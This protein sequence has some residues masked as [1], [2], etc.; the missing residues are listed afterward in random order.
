[1]FLSSKYWIEAEAVGKELLEFPQAESDLKLQFRLG[2]VYMGKKDFEIAANHFIAAVNADPTNT[3]CQK[4]MEYA[5]KKSRQRQARTKA[6]FGRIFES[7]RWAAEEEKEEEFRAKLEIDRRKVEKLELLKQE[8]A[9]TQKT[10]SVIEQLMNGGME[11]SP[12]EADSH[13]G[14]LLE[15]TESGWASVD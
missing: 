5:L 9:Q 8:R 10:D 12:G 14:N 11:F 4:W 3:E 7:D 15:S 1:V 2:K 13:L 6:N